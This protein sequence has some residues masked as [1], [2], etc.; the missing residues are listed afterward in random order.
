MKLKCSMLFSAVLACLLVAGEAWADVKIDEANFPDA[1]FRQWVKKNVANGGDVLTDR[2]IAAAE[3][4]D[5]FGKDIASL[6]GLKHF[7]ALKTLRCSGNPLSA[8]DVSKNLKLRELECNFCGLKSLDVSRNKNLEA[9]DCSY[10]ALS[11]L[12]ISSNATL[13]W[14]NCSGN[15]LKSIDVSRNIALETLLCDE[16]KTVKLDLSNNKELLFLD[17]KKNPLKTVNL[18][19]NRN[20]YKFSLPEQGAVTL[21]GG[22]TLSSRDFAFEPAG[23][24]SF[25]LN[26]SRFGGKVE[27]AYVLDN[28]HPSANLPQAQ[29]GVYVFPAGALIG[30]A[31]RIGKEGETMELVFNV[32]DVP[33]E[34]K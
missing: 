17:C 22:D 9:L 28:S 1:A 26:L 7:A 25:R 32:P 13:R 4:L 11:K 19:H 23:D 6:Q 31:Y 20:M 29:K 10:N 27:D 18:L 12:N 24:K 30:V 3:N 14:L 33:G 34:E 15:S 16:N 8:L 21:P 5:V 2:Q